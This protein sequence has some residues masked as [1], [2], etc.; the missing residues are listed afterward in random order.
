VIEAGR[1]FLVAA[2]AASIGAV[3]AGWRGATCGAERREAWRRVGARAVLAGFLLTTGAS[4]VLMKL[5]LDGAFN[6]AYVWGHTSTVLPLVYRLSAFWA[7]QEG[8]LLLWAWSLLGMAALFLHLHRAH[9][10]ELQPIA[11]AIFGGVAAFFLLLLIVVAPPFATIQEKFPDAP[12]GLVPEDGRGLNPL[13]QNPG[14]IVHPPLLLLGYVGFTIPFALAMASL[15]AGASTSGA[16]WLR[17]VRRWSLASWLFLWLGTLFGGMW[18]YV[19]LGWGGYWAWDPVENAALI[20]WLVATAYIHSVIIEE[21]RGMFRVWN[22]LLVALTFFLCVFGTFLTRSGL[23]SSV[24]SFAESGIGHWFAWFLGVGAAGTGALIVARY[25]S[26]RT[27]HR[28]ES[29]F[30]REA[31]FL[32]NNVV[33]LSMAASVLWGTLYPVISEAMTGE[34][35]SVGPAF[36]NQVLL[37]Q[38]LLLLLLTALGPILAWRRSNAA[39]IGR[40]LL[41]PAILTLLGAGLAVAF[42]VREAAPLLGVALSIFVIAVGF[43][44]WAVTAHRRARSTGSGHVRAAWALLRSNGRRYGGHLVHIGVGL[45]FIGVMGSYFNAEET[46]SFPPGGTSSFQGFS[47]TLRSV[48]EYRERTHEGLYAL[49]EIRDERGTSGVL[50]PALAW[51]PVMGE[52]PQQMTEVAIISRLTGDLYASN[53][54]LEESGFVS[55]QLRWNPMVSWVWFGGAVMLLGSLFALTPAVFGRPRQAVSPPKSAFPGADGRAGASV[56]GGDRM[57]QFAEGTA[58]P[59][60]AAPPAGALAG[61]LLVIAI[62]LAAPVAMAQQRSVQPA[63]VERVADQIRCS[64]GCGLSVARCDHA[65]CVDFRAEIRAMIAAGLSAGE[66]D[67]RILDAIAEKFGKQALAVPPMKGFDRVAWIFPSTLVLVAALVGVFLLRRWSGAKGG[68][69][70]GDDVAAGSPESEDVSAETRAAIAK[71][72]ERYR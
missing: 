19:E 34:R 42:D 47:V 50:K 1:I 12:P 64:C 37:P 6:V 41:W 31:T 57:S 21:R 39:A 30:S 54:G 10:R 59:P 33:L 63:E 56:L 46:I 13:L 58:W 66:A 28:I 67:Q 5:L 49:L 48:D 23:V 2:L 55:I 71:E 35:A 38:A 70:A 17:A 3:A 45:F 53:T 61:F 22:V 4:A 62:L 7:G 8:S 24:H 43:T 52:Q 20:P 26:L 40:S 27:P 14:M 65:S 29:I 25:K 36:F 44:D 68:E 32:F 11:I 51:Y 60:A 16:E 18:A 72:L 9:L 15:I 69:S